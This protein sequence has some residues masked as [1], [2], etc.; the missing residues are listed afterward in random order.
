MPPAEKCV[1]MVKN[2]ATSGKRSNI[3][4]KAIRLYKKKGPLVNT[5]RAVNNRASHYIEWRNKCYI[6]VLLI[7]LRN[8]LDN[9][10][11]VWN[12]KTWLTGED[13]STQG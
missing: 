6:H 4:S 2:D 3:Y 13:K 8:I 9:M 10:E 1:T 7:A 12:I 5:I 11:S